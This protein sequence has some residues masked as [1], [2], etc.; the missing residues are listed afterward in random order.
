V[1]STDYTYGYYHYAVGSADYT[2][3]DYHYSVGSADYTH[4]DYYGRDDHAPTAYP[5]DYYH[6]RD[7][8]AH[9]AYRGYRH[10][11]VDSLCRLRINPP[12]SCQPDSLRELRGYHHDYRGDYSS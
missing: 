3:S 12:H 10:S 7:N 9:P 6:E 4:S 11:P 5:I 2:Y 1:G 8:A